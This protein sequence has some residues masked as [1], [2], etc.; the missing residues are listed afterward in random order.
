M[1]YLLQ[2]SDTTP[3]GWVLTDT[4]IGIVCQF[5]EGQFNETQKFTILEDVDRPD[6]AVFASA[7]RE[8]TDWLVTDHYHLAMTSPENKKTLHRS[9]RKYIG[10]Q[11]KEARDEAGLSIRQLASLTGVDKNQISRIEAG[12]A[13]PTIDTITTLAEMLGL[14]IF[15]E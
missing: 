1:R 2:K 11:L 12:R 7:V 14:S 6:A 3:D 9:T 10:Q 8:M 4:E 15:I 5:I 13:N